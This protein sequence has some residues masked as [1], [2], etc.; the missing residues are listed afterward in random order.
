MRG[1]N[2]IPPEI[3]SDA[4]R[5]I[6]S[7]R[8]ELLIEQHGGLFSYESKCIRIRTKTGIVTV[9]GENLVIQYFGLQDLLIQGKIHGLLL[10][11]EGV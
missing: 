3:R 9:N 5:M 1:M 10:D 11:E 8:E 2:L 4:P 6:L 7:G